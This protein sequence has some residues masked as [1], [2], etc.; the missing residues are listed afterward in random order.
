MPVNVFIS[1]CVCF[2]VRRQ[3]QKK[4]LIPNVTAAIKLQE[5]IYLTNLCNNKMLAD[6][7]NKKYNFFFKYKKLAI[8]K[9]PTT[10]LAIEV[11]LPRADFCLSKKDQPGK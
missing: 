8:T 6:L 3:G 7:C 11:I 10:L 2:F 1:V 9:Y 5:D 4:S